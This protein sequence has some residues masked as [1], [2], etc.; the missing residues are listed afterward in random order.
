MKK[1]FEQPIVEIEN[2]QIEDTLTVEWVS[3]VGDGWGYEEVV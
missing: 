1:Y 3:T 2:I